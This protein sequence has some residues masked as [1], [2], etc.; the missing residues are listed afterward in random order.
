[1]L[2]SKAIKAAHPEV[3]SRFFGSREE[4]ASHVLIHKVTICHIALSIK[5]EQQKQVVC[6]RSSDQA[7]LIAACTVLPQASLLQIGLDCR[8]IMESLHRMNIQR[9]ALRGVIKN[10]Y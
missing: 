1:M 5:I 3:H 6:T 9:D 4:G 10:N 7:G 2:I 8:K